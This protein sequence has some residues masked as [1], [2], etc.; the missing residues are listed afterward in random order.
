MR[1]VANSLVEHPEVTLV[2]DDSW[3]L[4]SVNYYAGF[5]LGRD[6][7]APPDAPQNAEARLFMADEQRTDVGGVTWL[8]VTDPATTPS[9]G[10]L[11]ASLPYPKAPARLYA[12]PPQ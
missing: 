3:P 8:L 10:T 9:D 5:T 1:T 2:V 11:L 4:Y 12:L 7:L 6:T